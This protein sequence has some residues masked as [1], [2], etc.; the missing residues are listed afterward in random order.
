MFKWLLRG[1]NSTVAISQLRKFQPDYFCYFKF[2]RVGVKCKV[3][4]AV[5]PSVLVSKET[6]CVTCTQNK[7][8]SLC[9][10]CKV[11]AANVGHRWCH[12]CFK[13]NDKCNKCGKNPPNKGRSWC[14]KCFR[15]KN[16]PVIPPS[17]A[18][19]P[20]DKTCVCGKPKVFCM[21]ENKWLDFCGITCTQHLLGK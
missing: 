3:C 11:N 14:E 21:K 20:P 15:E 17:Q 9:T 7:L 10:K 1:R 19:P 2:Y 12:S 13:S 5:L 8:N 16:N 4:D 18:V 6:L